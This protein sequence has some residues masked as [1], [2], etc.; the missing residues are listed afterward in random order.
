[1][2]Y[3]ALGEYTAYKQQA[4]DA[5]NARFAR[6]HNLALQIGR[7]ADQPG[8]ADFAA[9]AD[10]LRQAEADEREFWA[11]FDRANGAAGLCAMP[12]LSAAQFRRG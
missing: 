4:Q 10:T 3:Q 9:L 2:N 7:I 12:E 6:L 8:G 1:M 11:A 5:A